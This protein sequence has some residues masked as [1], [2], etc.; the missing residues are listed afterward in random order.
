MVRQ[1][2]S[3]YGELFEQPTPNVQPIGQQLFSARILHISRIHRAFVEDMRFAGP[4]MAH[5]PGPLL[6]FFRLSSARILEYQV[7]FR[8]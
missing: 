5:L 6:A 3:P 4:F 8:E 1:I 7:S 2:K